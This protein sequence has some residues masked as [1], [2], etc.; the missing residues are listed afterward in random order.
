MLWE[1]PDVS[2]DALG[3]PWRPWHPSGRRA[4]ASFDTN[5]VTAKLNWRFN[6]FGVP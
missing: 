3:R 2:I 6:L 1:N 4:H 5:E